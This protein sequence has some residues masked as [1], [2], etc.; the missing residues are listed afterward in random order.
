MKREGVEDL[1]AIYDRVVGRVRIGEAEGM[2]RE[3][4]L[5]Q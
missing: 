2:E 4:R 1:M 5:P 3:T